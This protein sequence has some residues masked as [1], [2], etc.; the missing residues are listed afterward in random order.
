MFVTVTTGNH[1]GAVIALRP[2]E[3]DNPITKPTQTSQP[4]LAIRLAFVFHC[5]HRGVEYAINLGQIVPCALRFF[6]RLLSS[7]VIMCLL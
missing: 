7:Q 3:K 1:S 2:N 5:D 4:L 6:L